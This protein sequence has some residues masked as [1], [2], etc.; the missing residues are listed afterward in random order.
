MEKCDF[1]GWLF[2]CKLCSA[3]HEVPEHLSPYWGGAH[4]L[5]NIPTGDVE[6]ACRSKPGTARYSFADFVPYKI[7]A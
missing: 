1:D 5:S 4:T 6:L 7:T 3:E 2:V